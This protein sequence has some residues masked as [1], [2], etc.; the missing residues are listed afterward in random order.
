M[1]ARE[2][3][4]RGGRLPSRSKGREDRS[5]PVAILAPRHGVKRIRDIAFPGQG[6]PGTVRVEAR[7][8]VIPRQQRTR[9]RMLRE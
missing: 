5:L 4:S 8:R 1:K 2:P 3:S 9:N 7:S 6:L